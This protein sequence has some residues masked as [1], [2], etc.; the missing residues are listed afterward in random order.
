MAE[1]ITQRNFLL[2]MTLQK[3]LEPK[4]G[5]VA[6]QCAVCGRDIYRWELDCGYTVTGGKLCCRRCLGKKTF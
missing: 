5:N 1:P 4:S 6:G 3:R 2:R